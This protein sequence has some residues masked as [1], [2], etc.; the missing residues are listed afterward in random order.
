MKKRL[1]DKKAGIAILISLIIISLAEIIF[2]AVVMG[3][4]VLS[5]SNV[6]EQIIVI[7]L[8]AIIMFLTYKKK[9]RI[10][11]VLY[12]SWIGY[13]AF[14]QLFEL[15]GMIASFIPDMVKYGFSNL[16]IVGFLLHIISAVGVIAIGVLLIEYMNDGTI[17]NNAFNIICSITVLLIM[18][19]VIANIFTIINGRPIAIALSIFNN[20]YRL[21]MVFL[22][23][24]FAYD[25]A[26]A[27]LKKTNLTK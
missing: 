5:T 7:A 22:S 11:Y 1:H 20:L 27:Q 3:E 8:A 9:D 21:S 2:R 16:G 6:G 15:P 10:C 13:F 12:A 17:N 25:S 19:S 14:D 18:G 24:F 26:K 23:T 4:R